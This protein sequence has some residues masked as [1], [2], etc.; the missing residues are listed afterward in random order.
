MENET[1]QARRRMDRGFTYLYQKWKAPMGVLVGFV[2]AVS[3]GSIL[4]SDVKRNADKVPAIEQAVM[5]LTASQKAALLHA[6]IRQ[7]QVDRRF[8]RLE[9][10][11]ARFEDRFD[12]GQRE[13]GGKLDELLKR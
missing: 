3:G 13:I 11:Q 10:Q 9:A 2:A 7:Q 4:A 5:E 8:Q 12:A 1:Q 6:E